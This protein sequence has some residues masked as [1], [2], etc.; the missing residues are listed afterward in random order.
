MR[1]GAD[2]VEFDD[3]CVRVVGLDDLLSMKR[4]AH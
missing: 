2:T 4:A 1:D 3:F